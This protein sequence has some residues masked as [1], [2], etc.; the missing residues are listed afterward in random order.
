MLF[1]LL[2][3]KFAKLMQKRLLHIFKL[4]P[5]IFLHL[6]K[7][8]N[9]S[10]R[11]DNI[12][13]AISNLIGIKRIPRFVDHNLILWTN[14]RSSLFIKLLIELTLIKVI[15][16]A[17][18]NKL[19]RGWQTF[20]IDLVIPNGINSIFNTITVC[21]IIIILIVVVLYEDIVHRTLN[22]FLLGQIKLIHIS[23]GTNLVVWRSLFSSVHIFN[24]WYLKAKLANISCFHW[25]SNILQIIQL[26]R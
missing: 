23:S 9:F 5:N 26:S 20:L 22:K 21:L 4:T 13:F 1:S 2:L 19:L 12:Q 15:N 10:F 18:I 8:F 24:A 7:F 25:L 16:W 17:N 3:F 11:S 14:Y 6:L